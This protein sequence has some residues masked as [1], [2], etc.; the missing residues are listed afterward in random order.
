MVLKNDRSLKSYANDLNVKGEYVVVSGLGSLCD[1]LVHLSTTLSI[2][3][4]AVSMAPT[5]LSFTAEHFC[6]LQFFGI[7]ISEMF[8]SAAF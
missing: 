4:S 5:L 8:N 6:H 2:R 7:Y 1:H 3:Y